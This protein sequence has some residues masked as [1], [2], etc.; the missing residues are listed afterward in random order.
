MAIEGSFETTIVVIPLLMEL[1]AHGTE[2]PDCDILNPI[3][4]IVPPC[5]NY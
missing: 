1:S 4:P 2:Q 5:C 3:L